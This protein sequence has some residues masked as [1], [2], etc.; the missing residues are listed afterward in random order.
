VV[1]DIK[2][3]RTQGERSALKRVTISEERSLP[4]ERKGDSFRLLGTRSSKGR[5]SVFK[6]C[7]AII[8]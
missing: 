6:F 1:H 4:V 2:D 7:N 8:F 5:M 3:M